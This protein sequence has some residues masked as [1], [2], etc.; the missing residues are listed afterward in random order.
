LRLLW[1]FAANEMFSVMGGDQFQTLPQQ[2]FALGVGTGVLMADA[3]AQWI[4]R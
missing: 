4:G 1:L 3:F 2:P